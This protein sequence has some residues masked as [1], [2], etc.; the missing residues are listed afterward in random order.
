MENG[1]RRYIH[2]NMTFMQFPMFDMFAYYRF[3]IY[4]R[5]DIE[6]SN[7]FPMHYRERSKFLTNGLRLLEDNVNFIALMDHLRSSYITEVYLTHFV[8]ELEVTDL[9]N[10]DVGPNKH[11]VKDK[12]VSDVA[13][14]EK[15]TQRLEG[16]R[17]SKVGDR[18][19][20]TQ[21]LKYERII[22]VGGREGFTH[23]SKHERFIEGKKGD[24]SK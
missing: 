1:V 8:D 7:I 19:R 14:G 13:D 17:V 6:F 20:L 18:E 12:K 11:V 2:R 22:E 16:E 10:S 24:S 23:V 5:V 21:G 4:C 3:L 9:L 15:V